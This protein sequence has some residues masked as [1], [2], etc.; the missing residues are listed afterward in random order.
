MGLLKNHTRTIGVIVPDI[1]TYFFSSIISGI[2]DKAAEN[3]Y[4]IVIAS[5]QESYKKEKENIKNLLDLRVDGLIVCLSQDTMD[6][7]HYDEILEAEIP[8]VFFDR[9][10][11]TDEFSS[12]IIDNGYRKISHIA[13]PENLNITNERIIGYKEA[14]QE[15]GI[16][17]HPEWMKHCNLSISESA[18]VTKELLSLDP[19]PD[20]IFGVND[21][22]IFSAMKEIKKKGLKV[23]TDIALVGFSDEFHAT[24]VEPNLTA[25]TH[26]TFE[27]GQEAFKLLL[28]EIEST[29]EK[30]VKQVMLKAGLI[31]RESSQKRLPNS[32]PN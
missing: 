27:I 9:V 26:P 24:V 18:E 30:E 32:I 15:C 12:V 3:G 19:L 6:Y 29:S 4:Y 16:S 2:E 23:P 5:S 14:L 11:R 1:V 13:G 20:A 7:S 28:N 31:P 21:T 8:L 25:I 10:C 17:F 22:V